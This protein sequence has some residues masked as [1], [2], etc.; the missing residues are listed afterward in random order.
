MKTRRKGALVALALAGGIAIGA[1]GSTLA[2]G[3]TPSPSSWTQMM[4]GS[5]GGMMGGSSG[6]MMGG[7]SG[8]MMGGAVPG[9]QQAMLKQ[10]DAMHDAMHAA[11]EGGSQASPSSQGTRP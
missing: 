2:A 4:G 7:S 6:G 8:G 11:L 9:D 3:P 10:C 1:A 5:S